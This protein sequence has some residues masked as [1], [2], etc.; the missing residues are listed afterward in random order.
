MV[1]GEL[2]FRALLAQDG[3]PEPVTGTLSPV[4]KNQPR[5]VVAVDGPSGSGKSSTSREVAA[6]LGFDYLDTGAMYR[7]ATWLVTRSDVD[8]HDLALVAKLVAGADFQVR[9]DPR[10]PQFLVN[11]TDVTQAIRE[12]EIS[13]AVSAVATN[14]EVRRLLIAQQRALIGAAVRGIVVEGRDI[15]TVVAPD[16][17]VRVL[18]VADP[19]ARATRRTKELGN[20]ADE[21]AIHDQMSRRD[22]ADST[23]SEFMDAAP[24][25]VVIDS[26]DQTMTQVA[27]QICD[28]VEKADQPANA[29]RIADCDST[30]HC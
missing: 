16:A 7:A 9:T 19:A 5:C 11:G 8:A 23:V 6:R 21:Q 17:S 30:S 18:L 26:T 10:L 24:G 4:S 14:R 2:L 15:T 27:D 1:H 29:A 13:A 3:E 28:L 12:P 20:D 25:V 22:R